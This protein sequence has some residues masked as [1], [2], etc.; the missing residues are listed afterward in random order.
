MN[1]QVLPGTY[2]RETEA[3]GRVLG[4]TEP[5]IEG[6]EN[7]SCRLLREHLGRS[8]EPELSLNK[9]NEDWKKIH[10]LSFL[11]PRITFL[12]TD[13]SCWL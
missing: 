2:P 8:L 4:V 10:S 12:Q 6:K 9:G 13:G 7:S 5:V 1:K 11:D 3:T